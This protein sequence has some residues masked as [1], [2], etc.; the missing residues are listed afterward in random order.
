MILLKTQVF[1]QAN[2]HQDEGFHYHQLWIDGAAVPDPEYVLYGAGQ[3]GS[4][5]VPAHDQDFYA[6]KMFRMDR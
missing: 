5:I 4:G 3:L 6:L 1:G 2:Q